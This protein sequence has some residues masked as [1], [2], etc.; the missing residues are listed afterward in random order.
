MQEPHQDLIN[1][2]TRSKKAA[3]H[4]V[5]LIIL[6]TPTDIVPRIIYHTQHQRDYLENTINPVKF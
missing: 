4:I 5:H 2:S 1:I 3:L 6:C